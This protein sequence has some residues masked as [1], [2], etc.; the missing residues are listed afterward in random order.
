MR[1]FFSLY[2]ALADTWR[3]YDSTAP[4]VPHLIAEGTGDGETVFDRPTWQQILT[5]VSS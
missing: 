4:G 1:N 5:Q 2:R 3:W